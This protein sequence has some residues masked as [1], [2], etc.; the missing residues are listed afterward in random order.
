[1]EHR[2]LGNNGPTVPVFC[3]GAWPISGIMGDAPIEQAIATLNAVL[4]V[5]ITFIDTAEK[6]G[7]SESLIGNVIK[8]KRDRLFIATKLSGNHKKEHLDQAFENSLKGLGTD[9]IDL[10]QLHNHDS[11]ISI[12]YTIERLLRLKEQGKIRYIG[13]SNFDV[14]QTKEVAKYTDIQSVQ[15]LYN[16]LHRVNGN[17]LLPF[18]AE[19]GIGVM[20]Y[21]PLGKGLL[22]GH[23]K[24]GHKFDPEDIRSK[25]LINVWQGD[26]FD[27]IYKVTE[28][29]RNWA[30]DHGRDIIQ[31]AIAWV[32]ANKSVT[33]VIVGARKPNQVYHNIK[34]LDW[35]LTKN[36][37]N[38]IEE[39]LDGFILPQDRW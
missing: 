6:Y 9:Y 37:L 23:Y 20:A 3:Y 28:K 15:P 7:N 13:I 30:E 25:D 16:M 18:C 26:N 39:I 38:E 36:D 27:N 4:D 32:L 34:A 11:E 10:Y 33:T 21:S 35:K 24:A 5:G 1:M 14:N 19:N 22:T 17:D 8:G 2:K 29:L 31:L 12:E